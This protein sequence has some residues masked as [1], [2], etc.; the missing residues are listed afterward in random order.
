MAKKSSFVEMSGILGGQ[1][2]SSSS[3]ALP[4]DRAIT[5]TKVSA[6]TEKALTK[7][8]LIDAHRDDLALSRASDSSDAGVDSLPKLAMAE[9]GLVSVAAPGDMIAPDKESE[10][11]ESAGAPQGGNGGGEA[12]PKN[13]GGGL[14]GILG[15]GG[16]A[17]G[18]WAEGLLRS[19]AAPR[20]SKLLRR[21]PPIRRH[22][23]RRRVWRWLQRMIRAR[24]IRIA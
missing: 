13:G 10:L 21:R 2:N 14:L 15:L 6:K 3:N 8:A 1:K 20:K 5:N 22:L 17:S 9:D 24:A 7:K 12:A 4:V 11:K 19:R 18:A 23:R 16:L